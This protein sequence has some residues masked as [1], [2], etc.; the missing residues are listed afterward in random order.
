MAMSKTEMK[1]MEKKLD[2]IE[3][4]IIKMRA[5]LLPT[6]RLSKKKLAELKKIEA[7]MLKGNFISSRDLIKELG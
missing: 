3:I 4:E 2:R 7:D 1:M 5:A 6:E